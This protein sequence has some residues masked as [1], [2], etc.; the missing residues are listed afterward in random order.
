VRVSRDVLVRLRRRHRGYLVVLA[1]EIA[2]LL[3]MPLCQVFP[4]LLSVMMISLCIVLIVFVSRYSPLRRTR[5]LIFGLGTAAVLM[6]IIWHLA[7]RFDPM[8]GRLLTLPHVIAWLLFL[9]VALLRKVKTLIREP[10]VTTSVV[11]GAASGYL[12][13]GIAG[14]V[15]LIAIGVLSPHSF[16]VMALPAAQSHLPAML[17]LGTA[18]DAPALMAA[19][20]NMLTT[21]GSPV[22]NPTD[23]LGQVAI[24]VITVSGQL[25]VAILI[26]LILSRFH[27]RPQ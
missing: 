18:A 24:T 15:M 14:G 25:Y 20:F 1:V 3:S 9:V 23:V 21:V 17:T 10:F 26:A 6:E 5:P 27:K 11:M 19:A 8:L 16:D 13:V 2:L 12:L 7:L 22:V 4:W